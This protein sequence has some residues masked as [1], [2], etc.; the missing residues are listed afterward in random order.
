[1]FRPMKLQLWVSKVSADIRSQIIGGID[2]LMG[3]S[4][5]FSGKYDLPPVDKEIFKQLAQISSCNVL[6]STH[7][8]Y[9]R[10]VDGLAM[11]S[12]PAPHLANGWLSKYDPI[13]KGE[14]CKIFSR[15]MDDIIR[16]IKRHQI[17]EK[18]RQI[19][20]LHPN[21]KFTCEREVEGKLPFLDMMIINTKGILSST[22]YNKPTD[23]GLIMNFHALAPKKYKWSVVSGFVYRIYRACSNWQLFNTSLEKAKR[24][25]EK[26]QYPPDFYEPIIKKALQD[27]VGGSE[28]KSTS[29]TGETSSLQNEEAET[30]DPVPKK[31]LFVQYRGKCTE[32]YARALHRCKAPCTIVMTLQKLRTVLPSLKPSVEKEIRSGIVYKMKCPRCFACYVGYTIRHLKTRSGEHRTKKDKPVY[33]HLTQCNAKVTCD[34]FEILASSSRGE[35][36]LMTLEALWIRELNPTI[37][38]KDEYKSKELTIKLVS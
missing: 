3:V 19:N 23:T 1:M 26:N 32:D 11:G 13:I 33:K 14:G 31:L 21:L 10:Q 25:L 4:L 30:A 15:Y 38:T 7:E 27:I 34:D 12:P 8:G 17:E 16:N 2:A 35:D 6:M 20:S 36:Y 28:D 22:W 29:S 37:N 24:V 5:L 9:I 18:L